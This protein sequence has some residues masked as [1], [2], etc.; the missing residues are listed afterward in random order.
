MYGI[1][2][3]SYI[4]VFVAS[5]QTTIQLANYAPLFAHCLL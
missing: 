5:I 1:I 2:V 3:C 4:E